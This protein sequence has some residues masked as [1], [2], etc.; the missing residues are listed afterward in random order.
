[1][2]GIDK[3]E[4]NEGGYLPQKRFEIDLTE[5]ENKFVAVEDTSKRKRFI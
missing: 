3:F 4:L 1:M 5:F 2:T